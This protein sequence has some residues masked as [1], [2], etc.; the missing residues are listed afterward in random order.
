MAGERGRGGL[1]VKKGVG[2]CGKGLMC[3]QHTL[4]QLAPYNQGV[5]HSTKIAR[6]TTS[7]C[8]S[9]SRKGVVPTAERASFL[10]R[11]GSFLRRRDIC[12]FFDRC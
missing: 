1:T 7:L 10:Q 5:Q 9:Y 3:N 6:P 2:L 12:Q 11:T 4:R 8:R